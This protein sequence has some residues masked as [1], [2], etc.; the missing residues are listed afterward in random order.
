MQDIPKNLVSLLE[1][2]P[3][4]IQKKII[5]GWSYPRSIVSFRVNHL[6]SST[7]E[8]TEALKNASLPYQVWEYSEDAFSLPVDQEYTLRGLNIYREWKIYVQS[9]SSMMSALCLD[10]QPGQK[11]LDMAAAPGSKTTQM[12]SILRGKCHITAL[13]KFGIRH[14]KLLHTLKLQWVEDCVEVIKKDAIDFAKTTTEKYDRILLDAPCSSDGRINLSDDRTYK[15][16]SEEKSKAKAELQWQM[17]E[18]AW[19]LLSPTGKIVYST[20]S[21]SRWENEKVVKA[22]LRKYPNF[23]T[24]KTQITSDYFLREYEHMHFQRYLPSEVQEGF[25][26]ALLIAVQ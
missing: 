18:A 1:Q 15:W 2:F 10:L 14:E 13:E 7:E 16:Y 19:R 24:E 21:L 17:L 23:C 25:F 6:K 5:T 26:L 9:F 3:A 20:C 11:I 8:V 4:D 12:A 22:F